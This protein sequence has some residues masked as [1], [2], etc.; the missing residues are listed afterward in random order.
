MPGDQIGIIFDG[1][2][3]GQ[4]QVILGAEVL[5]IVAPIRPG[6]DECVAARAARQ[7]IIPSTAVERVVFKPKLLYGNQTFIGDFRVK[8]IT[9]NQALIPILS[10]LNRGLTDA[11]KFVGGS[12]V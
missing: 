11:G 10:N 5:N 2:D 12:Y 1:V 9:E 4:I 8:P 6:K 3:P 7:L